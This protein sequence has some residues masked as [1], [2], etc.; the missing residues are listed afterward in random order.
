MSLFVRTTPFLIALGFFLCARFFI[1]QP[2]SLEWLPVL[3]LVLLL[4]IGQVVIRDD[5]RSSSYWL[6]ILAPLMLA[7]SAILFVGILANSIWTTLVLVA[8]AVL[9]FWFFQ[10]LLLFA[11]HDE[12]YQP[13]AI[14]NISTYANLISVFFLSSTLASLLLYIRISQYALLAFGAAAFFL[15]VLQMLWVNKLSLRENIAY[16]FILPLMLVQLLWTVF[17]LPTNF[18][19]AGALITLMYYAVTNLA[20]QHLLDRLEASVA[21]RYLIIAFVGVLITLSTAQWT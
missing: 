10:N 17:W 15:F 3:F 19:V 2:H 11:H 12:R 8:V 20:R 18:F 21:R 6:L 9:L 1:Q 5:L 14:E 13:H 16:L 7:F 4:G